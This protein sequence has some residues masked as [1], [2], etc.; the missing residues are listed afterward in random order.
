MRIWLYHKPINVTATNFDMLGRETVINRLN[1]RG[2]KHVMPVGMLD[3][4]SEGLVVVTNYGELSK[5]MD[6]P[7][8]KTEREYRVCVVGRPVTK[9]I[10]DNMSKGCKINGTNYGPYEI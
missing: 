5:V 10:I 4:K 3:Y 1:L 2:L 8:I 7:E 9:T 6:K